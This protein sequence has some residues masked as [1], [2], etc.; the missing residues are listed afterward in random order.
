M[1]IETFNAFREHADLEAPAECCGLI[2]NET[3]YPCRNLGPLGTFEVSVDDWD[4]LEDLG[5][6]QGVCHSHPGSQASPSS[7]DI[8]GCKETMLPWYILGKND[9]LW[10]QDPEPIPLIGRKFHYGWADCYSIVR[11][12]FG[13]LPD[14]PRTEEFWHRGE[15]PYEE[16]FMDNGFISIPLHQA[17]R[18]DV[19]LIRVKSQSIPN[20]AAIYEGAGRMIHHLWNRF[21]CNDQWGPYMA[22]TTHV[23]RRVNGTHYS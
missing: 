14:F 13:D 15:N 8:E 17:E 10:R 19:I 3:Y 5:Q 20:H 18:G 23:L 16:H 22:N 2:I 9:E 11:D 21:S 1:M 6:I 4:R 7:A 12:Y